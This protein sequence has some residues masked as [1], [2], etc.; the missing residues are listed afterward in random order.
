MKTLSFTISASTL[1]R[2][3]LIRQLQIA[4]LMVEQYRKEESLPS[5]GSAEID[6]E[7]VGVKIGELERMIRINLLTKWAK[8]FGDEAVLSI[9]LGERILALEHGKTSV[10]KTFTMGIERDG[11]NKPLY[12]LAYGNPVYVPE[13]IP[14]TVNVFNGELTL[15][16]GSESDNEEQLQSL[17]SEVSKARK[18]LSLGKQFAK[19]R[20]DEAKALRELT[21]E[22][23]RASAYQATLDSMTLQDAIYLARRVLAARRL[24]RKTNEDVSVIPAWLPITFIESGRIGWDE[25][26]QDNYEIPAQ[27]INTID[28]L[29]PLIVSYVAARDARL[30]YKPRNS[31]PSWIEWDER[32]GLSLPAYKKLHPELA[33]KVYGPAFDKLKEEESKAKRNVQ[34]FLRDRFSEYCM[35]CGLPKSDYIMSPY[36]SSEICAYSFAR[37]WLKNWED[38]KAELQSLY[39]EAKGKRESIEQ[40]AEEMDGEN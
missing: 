37:K 26:K 12:R 36:L 23:E 2:L 32:D 18:V 21:E 10:L 16:A 24:W 28:E 8:T 38:R 6:R 7:W 5:D 31:W 25:A 14:F 29:N 40:K 9:L 15:E 35:N 17:K 4:K 30:S 20:K 11:E 22:T 19:A 33:S 27:T 39:D 3:N 34:Y 13:P 1:S